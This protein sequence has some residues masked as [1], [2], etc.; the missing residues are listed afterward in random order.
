MKKHLSLQQ[1][2][3]RQKEENP[4]KVTAAREELEEAASR[5]E[6]A[7]DALAA[8]MFALVSKETHLAHTLLQYVKLQRAYHESALHSLADTVPELER[9]IS[10]LLQFL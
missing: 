2:L 6:A 3:E 9:V 7:R 5:V 8:D 1:H 4:T 10:K